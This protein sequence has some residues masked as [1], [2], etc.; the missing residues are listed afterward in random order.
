MAPVGGKVESFFNPSLSW[1]SD[2]TV[3]L[4]IAV[5]TR[6]NKSFYIYSYFYLPVIQCNDE[7]VQQFQVF[8]WMTEDLLQFQDM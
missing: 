2:Y 7:D 4:S 8:W 5:S 1:L 3:I 6:E